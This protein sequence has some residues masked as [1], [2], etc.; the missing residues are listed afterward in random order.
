M[1]IWIEQMK[2]ID[3]YEYQYTVIWLVNLNNVYNQTINNQWN[4]DHLNTAD[5]DDSQL[6]IWIYRY[7]VGQLK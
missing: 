7:M 5:E 1:I 4:N 3:K 6:Q 2:M